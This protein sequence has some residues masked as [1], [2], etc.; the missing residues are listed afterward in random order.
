MTEVDASDYVE[1]VVSRM[2][3]NG[4]VGSVSQEARDRAA[5][6]VARAF[7]GLGRR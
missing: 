4:S 5:K 2:E 3:Q 1:R 7:S 6:E